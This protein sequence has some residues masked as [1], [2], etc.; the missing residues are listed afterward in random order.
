[1]DL[2]NEPLEFK[3]AL[4]EH[5]FWV[6]SKSKF[7][8]TYNVSSEVNAGE[9]LVDVLDGCLH[10]L[11]CQQRKACL[12]VGTGL[13][14]KNDEEQLSFN[15]LSQQQEPSMWHQ[16]SQPLRS[17][18]HWQQL[19]R[20]KRK[21]SVLPKLKCCL[22]SESYKSIPVVT[23]RLCFWKEAN[24]H[25]TVVFSWVASL[26]IFVCKNQSYST[27]FFLFYFGSHHRCCLAHC[28]ACDV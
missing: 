4:H 18:C 7:S 8:H 26:L 15:S 23:L 27:S 13:W 9:F 21:C 20:V 5:A 16:P 24:K 14:Q 6:C 28:L 25:T 10:A 1:M 17:G 2:T 3:R 12:W 11:I 19:S 22:F